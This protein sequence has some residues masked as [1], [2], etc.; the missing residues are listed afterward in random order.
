M[1][2]LGI[3]LSTIFA[4][5]SMVFFIGFI[6]RKR[7]KYF[8][9]SILALVISILFKETAV[10]LFVFLPI[11]FFIFADKKLIKEKAYPI[12]IL[13]LGCLYIALRA[14]MLFLPS[15]YTGIALVFSSQTHFQTIYNVLSYP[16]KALSQSTVPS[17][18]L[19]SVAKGLGGFISNTV[20]GEPGT[21]KF[22]IFTQ[23]YVLEVISFF[24]FASI[25]SFC[26]FLFKKQKLY[27]KKIIISSFIFIFFN[28]LIY[29]FSP[30]KSGVITDLD[31]RNLYFI[32]IATSLLIVSLIFKV[33]RI[34]KNFKIIVFML[35]IILNVFLLETKIN[36]LLQMG[37][38]R[39]MIVYGIKSEYPKLS[40]RIIFY[41]ESDKS[42]YGLPESEKIL[43][44]QS[45]F[46]QTLL[47]LYYESQE[48]S[49]R[50]F[51]N[52][53]LWEITDQGYRE[54]DGK[55]FGYFRD[56]EMLKKTLLENN[57][58]VE[59]VIAYKYTSM[60]DRLIN[61]TAEVRNKLVER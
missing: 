46:G 56:F 22:D 30:E 8:I 52:R 43:P 31:S 25:L 41:T 33:D 58:P 7:I 53:F 29:G 21:T 36:S 4:Y 5:L 14:I 3:H 19:I 17:S 47:V 27:D 40:E 6:D 57:L 18:V 24:V 15:S 10:G 23:K 32:S 44:F 11:M 60:A 42:F 12:I 28:G 45:G 54:V 1:A 61:I 59:S 9:F 49:E 48:Y 50:M 38:Q 20:A 37:D 55:G 34:S 26:F 35:T 13:G 39:K 16:F 2:D 51:D